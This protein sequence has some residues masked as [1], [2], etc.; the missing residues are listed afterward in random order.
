MDSSTMTSL[1]TLL[2]F[3]GIIQGLSMK[4]SKAVRKKL[5]LDAKGVDKKYINMK[6]NYL[7]VVGTV[8]LM[9]Q[10]TSYFKPELSE[11]LNI[12]LSA[13]LLLSITVDMVYRKIRRRKMLKKN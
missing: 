13:F 5:M 4:Y 7:I 9:V 11:K 12:L 10:V 3:T 1:M 6:I 8:L 2:A